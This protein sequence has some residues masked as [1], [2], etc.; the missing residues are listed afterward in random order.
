[1]ASGIYVYDFSSSGWKVITHE[2]DPWIS[3]NRFLGGGWTG[4]T[5]VAKNRSSQQIQVAASANKGFGL[6]LQNT[7]PF[8]IPPNANEFWG[9]DAD[10]PF[11]ATITF[12][13][14]KLIIPNCF[15]KDI[16]V[17][18][19]I[20]TI[21]LFRELNIYDMAD[22]GNCRSNI[23]V[24]NRTGA[25]IICSVSKSMVDVRCDSNDFELSDGLNES[26]NRENYH[27]NNV[28]VYIANK[29]TKKE[30]KAILC[31]PGNVIVVCPTEAV[32]YEDGKRSTVCRFNFSSETNNS[33]K[34][35][36]S[37]VPTSKT[38]AS[39]DVSGVGVIPGLDRV[40]MYKAIEDFEATEKGDLSF[41]E[42]ELFIVSNEQNTTLPGWW[43]AMR[44]KT[45]E[46]GLIPSTLVV[47]QSPEGM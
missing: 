44:V 41:A 4:T 21:Y 10:G 42:G 27:K 40:K 17:V 13:A 16:L 15:K 31:S 6:V 28:H 23:L 29:A 9:R 47:A 35:S 1:M 32:V 26:W 30:K 11:V 7:D 36:G 12:P 45:G 8:P 18:R 39:V 14:A 20:K 22:E 37:E 34:S 3:E 24:K 33:S 19:D 46:S 43:Q 5:F 25:S 2:Q 38:Q